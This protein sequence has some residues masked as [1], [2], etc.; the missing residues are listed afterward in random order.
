MQRDEKLA[1][2]HQKHGTMIEKLFAVFDVRL[3]DFRKL[4]SDFNTFSNL[5]NTAVDQSLPM[6]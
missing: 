5:F 2:N 6:D 3:V 1:I 4:E